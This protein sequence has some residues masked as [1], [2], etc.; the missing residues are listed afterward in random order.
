MKLLLRPRLWTVLA[1]FA[2]TLPPVRA[3]DAANLIGLAALG[4]STA[5]DRPINPRGDLLLANDGNFYIATNGGGSAGAGAIARVTPEGVV[6]TLHSLA[7]NSAEGATP[8]AKLMQASDGNLYGTTYTA[9]AD[10]RGTVFRMSLAG[11]FATVFSFKSGT[12][13]PFLPYGGLVQAADGN[14]YGTTLRG[15]TSDKGAIFRLATSGTLTVVHSFNGTDGENPEGTMIVAANGELYGTTLAGGAEGR[16]T[17]F[18]ISTSGTYTLIYSFPALGAFSAA[19]VAI[20]TTGANPRAGLLLAADGNFYG[21]AYQGGA[22]G[23]GTVFRMTP[24]GVVSAV[25]AFS[26]ATEGGAFPLAGVSQDAAGNLFGTTERGGTNNQGSAWRINTS[27]QFQLLHSFRGTVADGINPY[28]ALFPLG[29][30]LYGMS[31]SDSSVGGG[32]IYKFDQG[33]GGVLPVQL[34][35]SPSAMLVGATATLTW[36]SP[37]ATACTTAG[38]WTNTVAT[39]GTL[40]V[41]PAAAGIYTYVL[42]CTDNASVIR[43]AYVAVT[44]NAPAAQSVDGGG[45]GGGAVSLWLLALLGTTIV[46]RLPRFSNQ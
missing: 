37:T 22:S 42:T 46:C 40:A 33:V 2:V 23:Y 6:T 8:Y 45:G 20:N 34:A 21:T 28:T 18:R 41:T 12:G 43:N 27:N 31:Y 14:L 29:S 1:L 9:G 38:A 39:S 30:V 36:S 10:S 32:A 44:V 5:A 13:E 26:G 17:L 3:Q 24:A 25:H 15:G 35:A 16:G 7:G 19:G 11:D 4:S